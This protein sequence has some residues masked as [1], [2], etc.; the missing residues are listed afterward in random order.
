[1]YK[2]KKLIQSMINLTTN[3]DRIQF[4]SLTII[5]IRKTMKNAFLNSGTALCVLCLY[6]RG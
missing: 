3:K 2:D 4:T 5:L 6:A 1:M